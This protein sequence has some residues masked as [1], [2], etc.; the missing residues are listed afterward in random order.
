[1]ERLQNK[2]K[3]IKYKAMEI[4]GFHDSCYLGRYCGIYDEPRKILELVGYEV[5][6]LPDSRENS[7]C[8]GSCGG[9]PFFNPQLAS[10]LAKER[11][12][13]AK[14]LGIRKLIVCS[15]E[16]YDLLKNNSDGSVEILELSE[17]LALALGIKVKEEVGEGQILEEA[18]AN[19]EL[20]EE[21]KEEGY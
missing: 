12:L 21:L 16:N 18:K 1:L 7:L 6:E 14:R 20:A 17:V 10:R 15:F 2:H 11:I 5:R 3:L 9:L 13:Q 4:V 8:C 19:I